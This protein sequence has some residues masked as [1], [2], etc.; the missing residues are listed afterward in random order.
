MAI[1]CLMERRS[2][3][4]ALRTRRFRVNSRRTLTPYVGLRDLIRVLRNIQQ[5]AYARQHHEQ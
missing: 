1:Y 4:H 5:H 3:G 2:N